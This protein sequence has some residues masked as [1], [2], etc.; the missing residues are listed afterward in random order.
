MGR[1]SM[2]TGF[3]SVGGV[4]DSRR[5]AAFFDLDR[6][7][8]S[9]S[10]AFSFGVTAWRQ[11]LMPTRDL[12]SDAASALIF[13]IL[14][15]TDERS[16][17]VRDRFLTA[18][19]GVEVT[20]L[21]EI[22]HAMIPRLVSRVR[23]ESKR[24]VE[25]HQEQGRDTYIVSASPQEIVSR[26]AGALG[27]AGGIGTQGAIEDG[28]YT[29]ELV[30]PF[31]YGDGKAEAIA[32]LAADEGYD[33]SLSYAYSDSVSDLPMLELVGHPVAVNP[34]GALTD[35]ARR[36]GWPIV[37]FARTAKRVVAATSAS[38][39]AIAAATG[40]YFLGRRHGRLAVTAGRRRVA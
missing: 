32:A 34:D 22:G 19:A 37:M 11:K 16:N 5:A 17:S 33:L 2:S 26:L 14:G 30:G 31:V 18:V 35:V 25:M 20:Q 40:T 10:S 38:V 4:S 1:R 8:I 3:A 9:G 27:M 7:L 15:S 13:R 24:L 28:R 23:P 36:R 6:T 12:L 21:F 29:G 39:A